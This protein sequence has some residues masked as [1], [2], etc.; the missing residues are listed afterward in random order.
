VPKAIIVRYLDLLHFARKRDGAMLWGPR[1][2]GIT[3]ERDMTDKKDQRSDQLIDLGAATIVTK[4]S[5]FMGGTD[6]PGSLRQKPTSLD[7]D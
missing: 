2:G 5:A 7:A 1:F 3:K 4:G 6:D